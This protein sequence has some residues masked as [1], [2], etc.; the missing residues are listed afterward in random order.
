MLPLWYKGLVRGGVSEGAS[1]DLDQNDWKIKDWN[2]QE[3]PWESSLG[4]GTWQAQ[5]KNKDIV[6][7]KDTETVSKK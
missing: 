6:F 2:I 5:V 4:K 3:N 7:D 1:L